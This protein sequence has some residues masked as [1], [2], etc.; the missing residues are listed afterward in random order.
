MPLNFGFPR[1]LRGC[2]RNWLR[3]GRDVGIVGQRAGKTTL[4]A[5]VGP[6]NQLRCGVYRWPTI[7]VSMLPRDVGRYRRA[8]QIPTA[9][10]GMTVCENVLVAATMG[11]P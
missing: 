2:W 6:R 7:T 1:A 5:L 3:K 10:E 9:F 4:H 8:H 11:G